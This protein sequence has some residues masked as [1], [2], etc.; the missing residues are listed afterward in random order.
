[1]GASRG[2][3]QNK[4]G[5]SRIKHT[6]WKGK[7]FRARP[8]RIRQRARCYSR[9]CPKRKTSPRRGTASPSIPW[10]SQ[11]LIPILVS[12]KL[13]GLRFT[14]TPMSGFARRTN[15]S[16]HGPIRPTWD[17]TSPCP[18]FAHRNVS[19]SLGRGSSNTKIASLTPTVAK[20]LRE[21]FHGKVASV[22]SLNR[23]SSIC[24]RS[25]QSQYT[26]GGGG[27]RNEHHI[28]PDASANRL[29]LIGLCS[30]LYSYSAI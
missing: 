6:L 26:R 11:S 3:K 19:I 24:K 8:L 5:N 15:I 20:K 23:G 7:T 9:I 30:T 29:A 22:E 27:K 14:S 4:G 12:L 18:R 25:P 17:R 1:V 16:Q 10:Q 28:L 21:T 13:P 2:W